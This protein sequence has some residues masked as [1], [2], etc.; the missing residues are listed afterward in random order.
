MPLELRPAVEADMYRAAVIEREAYSPLETNTILFPGPFPSDV[1]NYRAEGWKK[2][3]RDPNTSCFK[4]IDTE[5]AEEEQLI[6]FSLW[7][8][9]DTNNPIPPVVPRQFPPGANADACELL[10]GRLDELRPKHMADRAHVFFSTLHTDPKHQ[11]RGAATM[12][13]RRCMENAAQRGLPIYLNASPL[14]HGMYLR[15]QFRD[16]ETL[17]TDFSQW[18]AK[19]LHNVF[20]MI[21]EP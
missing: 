16:I 17:V 4:V 6:A 20:A 8:H 13:L 5:L 7:T 19:N 1:L 14:G 2:Q 3:A 9:H 11:G 21:K 18:G 10:F 12:L 15:H